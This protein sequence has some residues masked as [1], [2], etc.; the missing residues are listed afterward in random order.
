MVGFL[1]DF[2][3]F[4]WF[5]YLRSKNRFLWIVKIVCVSKLHLSSFHP[6]CDAQARYGPQRGSQLRRVS[7]FDAK[8]KWFFLRSRGFSGKFFL[9]FF[10]IF[11]FLPKWAFMFKFHLRSTI[12]T[13]Q[14]SFQSVNCV[15]GCCVMAGR[16]LPPS[17]NSWS[18]C[19]TKI[20]TV[21]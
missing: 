15:G 7:K 6:K 8:S 3:S 21:W 4:Q 9:Y 16:C 1:V 2:T 20:T 10:F 19:L 12:M 13:E 11:F 17:A 5:S 18:Q 14:D